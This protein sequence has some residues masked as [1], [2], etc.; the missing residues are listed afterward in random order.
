M[1]ME[2]VFLILS[3]KS[4]SP[5]ETDGVAPKHTFI[6]LLACNGNYSYAL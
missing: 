2:L 5:V 1:K 6:H 4:D 3:V